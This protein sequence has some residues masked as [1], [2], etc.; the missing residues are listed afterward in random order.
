[1]YVE[2]NV[3]SSSTYR[4]YTDASMSVAV[5]Q[6]Q[7]LCSS[8]SNP[9]RVTHAEDCSSKTASPFCQKETLESKARQTKT[10][11]TWCPLVMRQQCLLAPVLTVKETIGHAS[12]SL[13]SSS[14]TQN[15]GGMHLLQHTPTAH[16]T[17][18]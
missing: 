12:I 5:Q 6:T 18:R 15:G 9:T 1:M 4:S 8:L 2:S 16:S 10:F 11:S 14:I 13:L 3:R 7:T 17:F